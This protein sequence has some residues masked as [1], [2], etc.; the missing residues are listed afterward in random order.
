LT[1]TRFGLLE[2]RNS[3]TR[4]RVADP[5]RDRHCCICNIDSDSLEDSVK[6]VSSS[7]YV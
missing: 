7:E 1:A 5:T 3:R 2:D 6:H 4:R